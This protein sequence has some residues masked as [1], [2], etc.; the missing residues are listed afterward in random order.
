MASS[1]APLVL[2]GHLNAMPGD[3]QPKI[4]TFDNTGSH[5]AQRH[6]DRMN[7]VFYL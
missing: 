2:P 5:T 7:D 1:Y 3:Y 4:M 6:V